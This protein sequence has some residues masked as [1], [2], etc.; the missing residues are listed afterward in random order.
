MEEYIDPP[1]E[2]IIAKAQEVKEFEAK[3]GQTDLSRSWSKWCNS[4]EYRKNEWL[5]RQG[6]A[7]FNK[8]H[9]I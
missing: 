5:F 1:A 4:Y 8:K 2:D 6:V 9:L 3:Y 7:I